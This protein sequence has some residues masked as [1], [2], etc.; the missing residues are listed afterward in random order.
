[1]KNPQRRKEDTEESF[2]RLNSAPPVPASKSTPGAA[3]HVL[4][5]WPPAISSPFCAN[6]AGRGLSCGLSQ[7][8]RPLAQ[9]AV[10]GFRRPSLCELLPGAFLVSSRGEVVMINLCASKSREPRQGCTLRGSLPAP[11]SLPGRS[12]GRAEPLSP[13]GGRRPQAKAWPQPWVPRRPLLFSFPGYSL[14]DAGVTGGGG[15]G[16][17]Q[18]H[19]SGVSKEHCLSLS[20]LHHS[21]LR[22]EAWGPQDRAIFY[23]SKLKE[24]NSWSKCGQ[25]RRSGFLQKS[26][27]NFL[28]KMR[29]QSW[30]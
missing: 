30:P 28:E 12:P 22:K 25:S 24:S 11:G 3:G 2:S 9:G 8:R 10:H 5:Q 20:E 26:K 6:Q 4:V 17:G 13:R 29:Y 14:R 23:Y 21:L 16:R 7:R 19:P 1:M 15:G 27:G 18:S